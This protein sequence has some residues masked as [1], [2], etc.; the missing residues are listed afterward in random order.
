VIQA[1]GRQRSTHGDNNRTLKLR[2]YLRSEDRVS[3]TGGSYARVADKNPRLV[4]LGALVRQP[5][6]ELFLLFHP[7]FQTRTR[8]KSLVPEEVYGHS[9]HTRKPPC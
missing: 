9:T 6:D 8:E 7:P 2:G 4:H 5:T 3:L 1:F